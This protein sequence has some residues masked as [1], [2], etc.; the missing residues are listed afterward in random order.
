[1]RT[2]DGTAKAGEDYH[3]KN[4]LFTMK[5]G[6]KERQVKIGIVNDA[7]W[8]P[9]EE[10][11]VQLIDEITQKR[12]QGDDTECTVTILDEDKPGAIGFE[13]RFLTV[14]RKDE[15]AYV[16]IHRVDGSDGTISCTVDT[17]N[18]IEK[19]A[20]KRAAVEGKDFM[21]LKSKEIVFKP[22][23]ISYK[24]EIEMPN[25]E[26]DKIEDDGVHAE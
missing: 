13:E 8:E 25:C 19:L 23:E 15:V 16:T 10:F 12:I 2:V 7:D 9:D 17:F 3:E 6:E 14:R 24:L 4:E 18:D 22:N 11:K 21:P 20:G 1:M 5:S 26:E